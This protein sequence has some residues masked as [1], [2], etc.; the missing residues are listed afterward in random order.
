MQSQK[1]SYVAG[2]S[3]FI[4]KIKELFD[5]ILNRVK[6]GFFDSREEY[7]KYISK[8]PESNCPFCEIEEDS[9]LFIKKYRNWSW[10]FANFPYWKYHTML[11]PDRHIKHFHQLNTIELKELSD[12]FEEVQNIYEENIFTKDFPFGTQLLMFWR[13]RFSSKSKRVGHLH[14][15]ISPEFENAWDSILD[16]DASHIDPNLLKQK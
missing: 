7:R 2:L 16:R 15:H 9:G 12:I 5:I 10:I 6:Q 1:G 11:V 13:Q 4:Q 8:L 14:L 3:V